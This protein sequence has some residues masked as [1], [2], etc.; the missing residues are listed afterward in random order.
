MYLDE[1]V[2][3]GASAVILLRAIPPLV[4]GLLRHS[5]NSNNSFFLFLFDTPPTLHFPHTKWK[6]VQKVRTKNS[7]KK[8]A[9]IYARHTHFL[10]RFYVAEV[11]VLH[12]KF[13]DLLPKKRKET[14]KKY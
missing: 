10:A 3:V 8:H 1:G 12:F 4:L 5:P 6:R 9:A 13:S 11:H 2:G 7:E 14:K